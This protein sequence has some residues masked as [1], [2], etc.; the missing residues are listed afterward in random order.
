MSFK[1]ATRWETFTEAVVKVLSTRKNI[2]Y[3]LWGNPAQLKFVILLPSCILFTI[4]IVLLCF[5]DGAFIVQRFTPV[6]HACS[7]YQYLLICIRLLYN[8]GVRG[9][10]VRTTR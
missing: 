9:L 6:S 8:I 7:N 4:V 2:V 1:N 3:L 5:I 10:T